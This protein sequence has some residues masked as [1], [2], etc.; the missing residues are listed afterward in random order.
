MRKRGYLL[1][2]FAVLILIS[3]CAETEMEEESLPKVE[4]IL[5]ETEIEEM[6]QTPIEEPII[7]EEPVIP[8]EPEVLEEQVVE[9]TEDPNLIAHWKFDD[10]GMDS[11]KSNHG[12]IIGGA[13]FSQGKLGKALYFDGVD[14]Y[15]DFSQ[16]T[17]DE[18]GSLSQGTIAFWFNYES[19]LDKQTLMP[20]FYI[21]M[22]SGADNMYLIEIGHSAGDGATSSPN[23]N[24]KKIYS[25][26]IKNN[27][28]PFLCYDSTNNVEEDKW[29][30]F[31]VVVGD[32]GNT[33]YLNG[34]EITNRDY[35]FGDANAKSFLNSIPVKEQLTLG[36]GRS[37]FMISPDFVYYK[38]YLD[39][40]RIYNKPL[41]SDE[42]NELMQ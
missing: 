16:E 13:I 4:D 17:V 10:D 9:E 14:D 19:L 37:S 26:W 5:S 21:G 25:T 27:R 15:V 35:N 24:D 31:A 18:I 23:P 30:H 36:H 8:E 41:S 32:D 33:G 42:I 39:D 28:E 12:N 22:E 34:V 40:V 20:I 6:E 38:G 2:I 11:A 7:S 1:S 3:G 29:H